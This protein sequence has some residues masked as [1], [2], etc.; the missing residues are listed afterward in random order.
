MWELGFLIDSGDLNVVPPSNF[1]ALCR[2]NVKPFFPSCDCLCCFSFARGWPTAVVGKVWIT[3]FWDCGKELVLWCGVVEE[4]KMFVRY[5]RNP[6]NK[7]EKMVSEW[8]KKQEEW[9]E[10]ATSAP[11]HRDQFCALAVLVVSAKKL[12]FFYYFF[13]ALK[14]KKKNRASAYSRQLDNNLR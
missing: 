14:L 10:K 5:Q 12:K 3:H 7:N 6:C 8:G 2:R 9:K 4:D 13:G 11:Q 1:S